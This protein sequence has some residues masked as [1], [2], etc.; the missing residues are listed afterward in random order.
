MS[1]NVSQF[2]DRSIYNTALY[3]RYGTPKSLSDY[4]AKAELMDFE[5]TRAQFE[6]YASRKSATRPA[7]GLIYWMLNNAWPSLHWNLFDYYLQKG[8]SFWGSKVGLREE[9]V[10]F[11]YGSKNGDIWLIN[12]SLDKSGTRTVDVDLL[13]LD[14]TVLVSKK[15]FKAT[16]KPN[17]SQHIGTV[18]EAS[19][20]KDVAFLRLILRHGTKILSRNTYWLP[21]HWDVDD[22]ANATWYN[23]PV[24]SYSDYTSLQTMKH[25]SLSISLQHKQSGSASYVL[26]NKSK[27]PATFIH[28]E[29]EDA[30]GAYIEGLELQADEPNGFMTLWPGEKV[31]LVLVYPSGSKP[32]SLKVWGGNVAVIQLPA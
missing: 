4:L 18:P 16:T 32:K 17:F 28:F 24:T 29:L 27:I 5:A 3:A 26:E 31:V 13:N 1:T 20:L 15:Q 22:V 12:H 10:S 14:G 25:A 6:A 2:Y 7:T 9:H 30:K 11:E 21:E 8:A 23:T 19:R